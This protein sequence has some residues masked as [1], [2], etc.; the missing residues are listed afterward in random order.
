[1]NTNWAAAHAVR[2]SALP[3]HTVSEEISQSLDPNAILN[4]KGKPYPWR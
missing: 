2:P 3:W 1:M 4:P